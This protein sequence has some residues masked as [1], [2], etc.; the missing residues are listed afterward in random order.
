MNKKIVIVIVLVFV[1]FV[2][3]VMDDLNLRQDRGKL[4]TLPM[5]KKVY[6]VGFVTGIDYVT[7]ADLKNLNNKII[8]N[9]YYL[10]QEAERIWEEFVKDSKAQNKVTY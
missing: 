2:L 3:L 7:G 5:A 9:K 4:F 1:A 10:Q 6:M 8:E